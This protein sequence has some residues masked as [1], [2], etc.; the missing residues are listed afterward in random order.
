M[1]NTALTVS[2]LDDYMLSV[3]ERGAR[4]F[5]IQVLDSCI[6]LHQRGSMSPVVQVIMQSAAESA[7]SAAAVKCWTFSTQ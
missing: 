1:G 5:A 4:T 7:E 2:K 3:L 6:G